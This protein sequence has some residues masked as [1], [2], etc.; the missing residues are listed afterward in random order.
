[1]NTSAWVSFFINEKKPEKLFDPPE[2]R[3]KIGTFVTCGWGEFSKKGIGMVMEV[4][5]NNTYLI[6]FWNNEKD[7]NYVMHHSWLTMAE[8]G[9]NKR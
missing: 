1:M 3:F 8:H 9:L 5:D 6:Q 7:I 4:Y 2:G